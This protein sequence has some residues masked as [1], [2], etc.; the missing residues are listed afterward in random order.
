ME[1]ATMRSQ[2]GKQQCSTWSSKKALVR[3]QGFTFIETTVALV[4][5]MVVGLG[6][7]SLFFYAI[8]NNSGAGHRA[9]AMAVGQQRMERLRSVPFTDVSLNAAPTGSSETVT[10]AGRQYVVTTTIVNTT[11][12]LKTI[13]IQVAP[14]G[15]DSALARSPVTLMTQRAALSTGPYR[16]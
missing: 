1:K 3:E 8:N 7:A 16:E 2:D 14:Q 11:P 10:S 4:V 12:T 5:I 13:T 6:A 9:L 15:V